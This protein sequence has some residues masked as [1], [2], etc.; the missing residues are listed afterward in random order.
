[1]TMHLGLVPASSTLYVPFATYAGE[2]GA[3]VTLTGLLAGDIEIYKDGSVTQRAS[4]AGYTLLDTDGIDFDG[5][6]GIHGFSIDLSDNTDAGFYA[7]GSWYW[8]VV[9]AVTIDSQTVNFIAA[10]FRIGPAETVTGYQPVDAAALGGA[11]QSA[12]DLR[13]FADAGYDP[14]TNKV[15]GVVLT[16]TVTTYTGNTV[17][18]GD[19][20]A[21][22][23]AP[24]G[25]SVSAD[26]AAVKVDTAAVK[27]KTDYLP[28]AT[29]GN[30]GGVF[31]AGTNAATTITTALTTTFTGNLTGSVGSV[32]GAVGSVTGAVGSVTSGVT[33]TT[34]N[35]KTGYALSAAGIQA[36]WD[37][38]T[39]ALTTAGSIGKLL[40][41]NI[42]A[43][44]SSRLASASYTAPLD[45][46]GT[47]T[48]V[49]L[50]SANLDTQLSTI[51][52]DTGTDIPATLATMA[53]YIDTEV[54]AIKT[55]TDSL[56]FTVAGQVDA[57]I[58]YVN[59]T[60]VT[61]N[62]S[63]GTEWGP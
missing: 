45:A 54:A 63:P 19:S 51:V 53:G 31:I 25:A 50:A 29:A 62:G 27:T 11:V 44:I 10:T 24:A 47:R 18:T 9:S 56:T 17:Q 36:V 15:Q 46:A 42:N 43:T 38:L 8:V 26:V 4:D 37:A 40:V 30:A 12:T 60:A 39:S 61:G 22:L 16:D 6:T 28:S 2:T 1:M 58:Q 57:N 3:S 33:V 20:F 48:A 41:D 32:T 59:D 34:N 5:I 55:K 14:G 35:D 13:D 49:G 52:T 21:R 23:G 7:V